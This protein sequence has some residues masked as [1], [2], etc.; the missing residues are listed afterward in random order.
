MEVKKKQV[1]TR[2]TLISGQKNVIIH[3]HMHVVKGQDKW[4]EACKVWTRPHSYQPGVL[5]MSVLL[6]RLYRK[7]YCSHTANYMAGGNLTEAS[8]AAGSLEQVRLKQAGDA[9][10]AFITCNAHWWEYSERSTKLRSLLSSAISLQAG[11]E[12]QSLLTLLEADP[13]AVYGTHH[14]MPQWWEYSLALSNLH[15]S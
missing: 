3:P 9:A 1:C 6:Y 14:R 8:R 10:W 5:R 2:S 7:S 4:E 12:G 13:P 11:Y 15:R